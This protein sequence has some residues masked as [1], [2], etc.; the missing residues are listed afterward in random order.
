LQKRNIH[1]VAFSLAD[2]PVSKFASSG[3]TI[4][5]FVERARQDTVGRV[6][7]LLDTIAM[8]EIN[9]DIKNSGVKS[10]EL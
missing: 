9:I 8:M 3:E 4:L 1:R 2:T 6:E 7:R 5:L 10:Q